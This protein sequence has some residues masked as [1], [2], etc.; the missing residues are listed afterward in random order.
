MSRFSNET[1]FTKF[2]SI[3]KNIIACF[4]LLARNKSL[5]KW[6]G[7]DGFNRSFLIESRIPRI[8]ITS[9]II[10]RQREYAR[11]YY[12]LIFVLALHNNT[13]SQKA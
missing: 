11:D 4:P 9:N 6:P 5:V 1:N 2:N 7:L 13:P 3:L 8:I 12:I 10:Y